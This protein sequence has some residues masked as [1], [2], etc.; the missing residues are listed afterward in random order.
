MQHSAKSI[1]AFETASARESEDPGAVFAEKTK[2]RKSR[3]SV[4]LRS[5]K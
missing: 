4:P 2:G 3:K 1:F 5:L